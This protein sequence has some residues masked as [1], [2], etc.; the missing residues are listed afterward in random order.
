MYYL[1]KASN[2]EPIQRES[3]GAAM[4]SILCLGLIGRRRSTLYPRSLSSPCAPAHSLLSGRNLSV[5]STLEWPGLSVW[6]TPKEGKVINTYEGIRKKN[7]LKCKISILSWWLDESI[8]WK[9]NF[10][11]SSGYQ[12]TTSD[13]QVCQH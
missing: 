1:K 2:F 3:E 6:V 4:T 7:S 11:T 12:L 13:F 10:L 9:R 8:F 5:S